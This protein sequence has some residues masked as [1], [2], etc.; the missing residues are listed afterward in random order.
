MTRFIAEYDNTDDQL[1]HRYELKSFDLAA[2][3][4]EFG[5]VNPENQMQDR[6]PVFECS[7]FVVEQ[8]LE[9]KIHWNFLTRSYYLEFSR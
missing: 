9:K 4:E 6:Y 8:H 2:F 5:I 3:Q 7:V 1:L